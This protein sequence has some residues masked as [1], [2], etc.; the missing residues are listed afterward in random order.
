MFWAKMS[1][2]GVGML[3][4]WPIM[5]RLIGWRVSLGKGEKPDTSGMERFRKFEIAEAFGI[6]LVILAAALMARGYG[7]P[8]IQGPANAAEAEMTAEGAALYERHCQACHQADGRGFDGR[9]AADFTAED[10][11]LQKGNGA[12]LYSIANGVPGTTMPG[13]GR[14]LDQQEMEA[15]LGFVRQ[16]FGGE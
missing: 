5:M 1:I 16:R 2:L 4:E 11:P 6:P 14:S 12:L 3:A 9:L 7:Q 15:V 8:A 10:S 13:W